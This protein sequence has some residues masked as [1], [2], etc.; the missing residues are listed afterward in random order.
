MVR[1]EYG[2][3]CSELILQGLQILLVDPFFAVATFAAYIAMDQNC[4][5]NR[6][7]GGDIVAGTISAGLAFN[8]DDIVTSALGTN[9]LRFHYT[10]PL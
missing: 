2:V 1:Q 10:A 6:H 5:K 9:S 8:S 7:A 3:L 4:R